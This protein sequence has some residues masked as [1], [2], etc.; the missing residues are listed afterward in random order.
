MDQLSQRSSSSRMQFLSREDLDQ[1]GSLDLDHEQDR[2]PDES[3]DQE[4]EHNQAEEKAQRNVSTPTKTLEI[5]VGTCTKSRTHGPESGH[6]NGTGSERSEKSTVHSWSRF[7][8]M[9]VLNHRASSL[10]LSLLITLLL[11]FVS[12]ALLRTY[13]RLRPLLLTC[14]NYPAPGLTSLLGHRHFL[15]PAPAVTPL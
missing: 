4:L 3:I 15:T 1:E 10:R 14:H 6:Q 7:R 5:K 13:P 9:S 8:E 11:S 2:D 12:A